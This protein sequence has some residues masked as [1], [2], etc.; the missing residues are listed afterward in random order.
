MDVKPL[1]YIIQETVQ[2][3]NVF[4][5]ALENKV[6]TCQDFKVVLAQFFIQILQ[7]LFIQ[8]TEI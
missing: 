2:V 6:K 8:N 7:S 4:V 1:L 3:W 5:D